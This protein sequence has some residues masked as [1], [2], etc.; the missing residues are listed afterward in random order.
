MHNFSEIYNLAQKTDPVGNTKNIRAN[1]KSTLSA[2]NAYNMQFKAE[3]VD[4]TY[5]MGKPYM[6]VNTEWEE[7][8]LLN[9]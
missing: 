8:Y 2:E 3:K 1:V 6:C 5:T 9:C 4:S 7:E